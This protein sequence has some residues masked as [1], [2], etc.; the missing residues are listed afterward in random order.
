MSHNAHLNSRKRVRQIKHSQNIKY[1]KIYNLSLF[2]YLYKC[3]WLFKFESQLEIVAFP[4]ANENTNLFLILF[5]KGGNDFEIFVDERTIGHHVDSPADTIRIC[6]ELFFSWFLPFFFHFSVFLLNYFNF[7]WMGNFS[8]D[9][10]Y[11]LKW[12]REEAGDV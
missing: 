6:R 8:L 4:L 7:F 10:E 3:A 5:L 12:K 1:K 11:L 2:E 9:Y